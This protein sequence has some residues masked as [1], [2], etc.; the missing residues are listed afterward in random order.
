MARNSW[1]FLCAWPAPSTSYDRSN[2]AR[3]RTDPE[4]SSEISALTELAPESPSVVHRGGQGGGS[5]DPVEIFPKVGSL[6]DSGPDLVVAVDE[7]CCADLTVA[8][9][10]VFKP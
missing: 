10:L 2:L 9:W 5:R 6:G 4:S 1:L 7:P 3:T 8:G